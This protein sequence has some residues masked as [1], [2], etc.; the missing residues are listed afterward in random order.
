M[1]CI[2]VFGRVFGFVVVFEDVVGLGGWGVCGFGGVW[3]LELGGGSGDLNLGS[4][5]FD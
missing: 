2:V 3:G 1:S 5:G 4:L